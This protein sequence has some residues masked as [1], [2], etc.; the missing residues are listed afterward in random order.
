MT[1]ERKKYIDDNG[2]VLL[3][4]APRF[5]NKYKDFDYSKRLAQTH[6]LYKGEKIRIEKTIIYTNNNKYGR[7]TNINGNKMWVLMEGIGTYN[8]TIPYAPIIRFRI[9]DY[10]YIIDTHNIILYS[11]GI[12]ALSYL[13][14]KFGK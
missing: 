13:A 10:T 11:A 4:V 12:L 8:W 3:P 6:A 14:R 5:A 7:F 9:K 1:E 2:L